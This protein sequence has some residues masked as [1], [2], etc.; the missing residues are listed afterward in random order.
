V[1]RTIHNFQS[2]VATIAEISRVRVIVY[3]FT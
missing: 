3:Q 2:L 1:I